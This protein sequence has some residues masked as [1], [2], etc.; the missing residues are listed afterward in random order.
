MSQTLVSSVF[1]LGIFHASSAPTSLQQLQLTAGMDLYGGIDGLLTQGT[2]DL[3]GSV[4]AEKAAAP[5]KCVKPL[6]KSNSSISVHSPRASSATDRA[7]SL[8]RS[9]GLANRAITHWF[10]TLQISGLATCGRRPAV[11]VA[12]ELVLGSAL[13]PRRE[14]TRRASRR[15]GHAARIEALGGA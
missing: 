14:E 5:E 3:L 10:S 6:P 9:A 8:P 4:T 11:L 15:R 7:S 2:V 1:A 12:S 13:V